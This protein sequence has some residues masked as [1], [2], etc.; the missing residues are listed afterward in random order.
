MALLRR[1]G[2]LRRGRLRFVGSRR[3][4]LEWVDGGYLQPTRSKCGLYQILRLVGGS[5][6]PVF[7][8]Y[9]RPALGQLKPIG[10]PVSLMDDAKAVAQEHR[11]QLEA[12]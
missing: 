10:Q 5:S 2:H 8:A 11:E 9:F 3:M 1:I 12:A 7:L 6:G 4:T